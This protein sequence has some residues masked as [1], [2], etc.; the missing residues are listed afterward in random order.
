MT[1]PR[2]RTHRLDG[3]S[4]PAPL[5]PRGRGGPGRRPGGRLRSLVSALGALVALAALLV[6]VPAL[7]LYGTR[8]VAAMG[9]PAHSG[10]FDLLTRP[11]DGR[12]FLWALVGIG[13]VAWLCFALSV[14]LEIPAQ[15]RGRVARRIPTLGWSQRAAAGLVGAI[16]ALL[17]AA[18][19]SFAATPAHAPVAITAAPQHAALTAAPAS[20]ATEPQ[21][22][23]DRP[24]YTVRDSRPADSLWS[25]AEQRLGSGERWQEIARLNQGRVMDDEGRRFDADRP[26][27]PGWR[28]LMP[29]DAKPDPQSQVPQPAR[30]AAQSDVGDGAADHAGGPDTVTVR[31]GDTLSAIA[32]RELGDADA[33]TGL[34]SANKGV[35]APDGVR[36][37][38]PD[39]ITPGMV[40]KLPGTHTGTPAPS[41][42]KPSTAKPSTP[43]PSTPK[44]PAAEHPATPT[45]PPPSSAAPSSAP[46]A[47]PGATADQADATPPAATPAPVAEAEQQPTAAAGGDRSV[48]LAASGITVL[49]AAL[50]VGTVAMRRGRQQQRRRPRHRIALPAPPAAAFEAELRMRQDAAGLDLVDRALRTLARNALAAGKRL[51]AVIAVRITPGHNVELHLS[52]PATPIAPF[53]AAHASTSWWCPA[54]APDLLSTAEASTVTAP[55]PAL[56]GLGSS[57][58]GGAVLVDL[59][60]VRLLHI[61]GDAQDVRAVLRTVALE[62][63]HSPFADGLHMHLVDV[64][65]DLPVADSA[66]DRV[67]R[68]DTL[69]EALTEL[70]ARDTAARSALL[71]AGAAH[72]R[73]ARSR[74]RAGDA[75]T[76]EIVLCGHSPAGSTPA[77]LGRLLDARPRTCLV[78]VT[79]A[80]ERGSGPMA[81]WTLSTAGPTALPGLGL[82][83]EL[84]RLTDEQYG[85]WGEL[86]RT[87]GSME[88]HPAPAWTVEGPEP[89]A[90]EWPFP[91]RAEPEQ[92]P[93]RA[94]L[95]AARPVVATGTS[96][97]AGTD[98]VTPAGPQGATAV[99]TRPEPR[100]AEPRPADSRPAD[101]RL[102]ESRPAAAP[103]PVAPEPR[104]ADPRTPD[105]RTQ[106][107]R[108]QDPRTADP[109]AVDPRHRINGRGM[110]AAAAAPTPEAAAPAAPAAT[111]AR[112]PAP[113]PAPAP[114]GAARPVRTDAEELLAILRSPR[115]HT[116]RSAPRVRLLGPVDV[117]GAHGPVDA[118]SRGRLTEVGAYLAL[119]PGTDQRALDLVL[120]PGA[121]QRDPEAAEQ[122]GQELATAVDRLRDWLG[123]DQEG[124]SFLPAESSGAHTFSPA[125]TC[126]WDDFRSLYRRGMRS[127]SPAA[128]AALAHALALVRGAP[129]AEVERGAYGWAEPFRQD[130]VAAVLDTAHELAARR[131]QHGDF[132]S[133]EAAA[134]RGLAVAPDAE[135][136]HRD[137]LYVYASA[138]AREQLLKAVNRLD[139]TSRHASR[140]LEPE[141]VALLHDLIEQH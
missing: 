14:L 39:L 9:S 63:A 139:A 71:A 36:L 138:G 118:A 117:L 136:L 58:D 130:M 5:P 134:Y 82:T 49:L 84:Q 59:E 113:A 35:R 10:F 40:L 17:P 66:T 128:D 120:H 75:W 107:P 135:L 25:I 106:G 21:T 12:L 48:A 55:Y 102:A 94:A 131:L 44:P 50:L 112:T 72:P 80:P 16:V 38:N 28:L 105:P 115:A 108:T 110:H 68:H 109:R 74:G 41:T 42:A 3:R 81:R 70:A 61:A 132:R 56:V 15:L 126:D 33:W 53:R 114:A 43:K 92:A 86:L 11:D 125:V 23:L 141:T 89:D 62:L 90:E 76:P 20:L 18:G 47:G 99:Q 19:A 129:F 34:Y 91:D 60:A 8:A 87:S 104:P 30:E 22:S 88:Q 79:Q 31:Q 98:P 51:P 73:E 29:A 123:Q 78:V 93:A 96:A 101:S 2:A 124:R 32:K 26:I 127:T 77:E 24:V 85:Y 111:P 13:W 52:V 65:E 37:T 6:G 45:T 69:E 4:A 57:P 95:P 67:R 137:L 116:V 119:N 27:Y 7:L 122:A 140:D 103:Q 100:P 54:D 46:D 83:V 121:V 97:F 133:A 1:V 64:A